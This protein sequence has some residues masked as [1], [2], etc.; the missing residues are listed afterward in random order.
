[1]LTR[2]LTGSLECFFHLPTSKLRIVYD[3]ANRGGKSFAVGFNQPRIIVISVRK[4]T[5]R[6][7]RYSRHAGRHP[8]ERSNSER[9]SWIRMNK[10]VGI[11][12]IIGEMFFVQV[13]E[14]NDLARHVFF[15]L[16]F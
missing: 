9:L 16:F 4:N 7:W 5:T 14:L 6:V 15:T 1:M 2:I 3:L 8:F 12:V 10:D 11:R 13:S